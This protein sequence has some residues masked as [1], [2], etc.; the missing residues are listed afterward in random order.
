MPRRRSSTSAEQGADREAARAAAIALLSRR[1]FASAALREQLASRGF[2][3]AT[4]GGVVADLAGE[5][6]VNDE[7]YAQYYVAYH[8]GR[9]QGPIRIAAELRR[10][11]VAGSL[12]E[13]ALESGP[14]WGALARRVR[15]AKFGTQPPESWAQKARQARFL[16]Y[17]GFSADHIRV[18]TG[19]DAD[20]GLTDP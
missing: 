10:L 14:D 17:R 16:Q 20:A 3:E 19:V 11:G 18:A 15:C 2:D 9:G 6:L 8:A 4:A 13:A 12:I 5:G 1:D 7:R